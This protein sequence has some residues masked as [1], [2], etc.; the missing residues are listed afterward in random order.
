MAA[1]IADGNVLVTPVVL[2]KLSRSEIQVLSQE[3]EKVAREVRA[4]NPPLDDTKLV[5]KRNRK[6]SRMNQAQMVIRQYL[7][8]RR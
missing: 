5:Q 1:H 4:E 6:V 3:I 7:M 2:K 8:T